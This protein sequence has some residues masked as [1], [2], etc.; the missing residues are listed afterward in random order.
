M[1]K[2]VNLRSES[3]MDIVWALNQPRIV[4]IDVL[5][6]NIDSMYVMSL[7][8]CRYFQHAHSIPIVGVGK[9]SAY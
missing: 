9:R 8:I 7:H 6:S 1:G 3:V 2:K 5:I 4:L